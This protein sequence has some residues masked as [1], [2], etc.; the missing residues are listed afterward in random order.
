VK[1]TAVK[2]ASWM[3]AVERVREYF[4][5]LAR[6]N[7]VVKVLDAGCGSS[8]Y[9]RFDARCHVTGIDISRDQLAKNQRLDE[10]IEG[11][12]QTFDL[13]SNRFDVIVCWDVLEHLRTPGEALRRLLR[14]VAE[15]GLLI[16]ASPNP[17]SWKGAI[18][19]V[20]PHSF[21]EWLYR[22]F[23]DWSS[24]SDR[25]GPF[26][27][28]MHAEGGPGSVIELAE[29]TG[30]SCLYF[31]LYESDMQKAMRRR[32]GLRNG[33]LWG[34]AKQVAA[35][36]SFRRLDPELTDY[37]IVLRRLRRAIPGDS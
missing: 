28:F 3:E 19:R 23:F 32:L 37:V 21:H 1:R 20:T 14:A 35:L 30:F 29:R 6:A 12:L 15:D 2:P 36:L 11:D 17:A 33:V 8:S 13:G 4:D 25:E 18:A 9:L 26:P 27:T 10:A 7:E 16:V 22:R 34:L 24:E 31:A 5:D